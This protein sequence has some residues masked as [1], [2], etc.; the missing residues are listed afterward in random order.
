MGRLFDAA[1]ALLGVCLQQSYE[2]QAAME[3]EALV[4]TPRRLPGGYRVIGNVLDFTPLLGALL[5][6]GRS[7]REGAELFHGTLVAGLAEWTRT[8]AVQTGRN[9]VVLGGGCLLNRVLTEGLVDALRDA[10][11]EPW[12]PRAVPANDGGLPLGQA[13]IARAHLMS[14]ES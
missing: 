4:R 9:D 11:L 3:L 5:E 14:V 10:G 7:A 6:P 2:G 12:L 13:A 8:C 1:A